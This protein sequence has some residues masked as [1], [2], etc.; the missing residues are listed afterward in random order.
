MPLQPKDVKVAEG[1]GDTVFEAEGE[2]GIE[3]S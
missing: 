2:Q 1:V 3:H